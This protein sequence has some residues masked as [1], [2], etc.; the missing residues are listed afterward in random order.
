M[1]PLWRGTAHPGTFRPARSGGYP[2]SHRRRKPTS[3]DT[4]EAVLLTELKAFIDE[5]RDKDGDGKV[6]FGEFQEAFRVHEDPGNAEEINMLAEEFK[7]LK[8]AQNLVM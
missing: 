4:K 2:G 7:L 1:G 6:S 8:S 3:A 5:K